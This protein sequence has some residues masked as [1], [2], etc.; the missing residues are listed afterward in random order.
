MLPWRRLAF[1][2][3]PSL[4]VRSYTSKRDRTPEAVATSET[5][6]PLIPPGSVHHNDLATFLRYAQRKRLSDKSTVFVGTH[7]EYTVIDALKR[8]GFTLKRTGRASDRGID[9]LGL[10]KVPNQPSP[11]R[12]IVQCKARC[13]TLGPVNFRELEG[14]LLDAPHG[15]R[16]E[17][18]MGLL[19][20]AG[21]SSQGTRSLLARS[22]SPFG[23][24]HVTRGGEVIQFFWNHSAKERGLEGLSATWQYGSSKTRGKTCIQHEKT[25]V[26]EW[27]GQAIS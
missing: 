11:I 17:G 4:S 26:L 12:V 24:L 20:S 19:V 25:L 21:G 14:A 9:L 2:C 18:V 7:Y 15:W 6:D 10:W 8:F 16:S 23:Y 27:N 22:A 5:I 1:R 13:S 3:P